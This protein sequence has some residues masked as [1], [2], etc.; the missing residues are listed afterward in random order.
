MTKATKAQLL[1]KVDFLEDRL[2]TFDQ[3][4]SEALGRN[5]QLAE[6]NQKLIR[7][8]IITSFQ[9]IEQEESDRQTCLLSELEESKLIEDLYKST[10]L[11]F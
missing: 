9:S 1:V 2:T 7:A 11:Y 4:I 5:I 3:M 10:G 6:E 8:E